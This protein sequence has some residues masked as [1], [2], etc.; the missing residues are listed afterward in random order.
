MRKLKKK[1]ENGGELKL[2]SF[3]FPFGI[4]LKIAT[5]PFITPKYGIKEEIDKYIIYFEIPGVRKE[6]IEV[7]ISKGY[8]RV[9]AK[10][11]KEIRDVLFKPNKYRRTIRIPEYVDIENVK[12]RYENGILIVTTPKKTPGR[13]IKVE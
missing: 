2:S 13:R 3:F 7:Y 9:I 5:S 10:V 12:S 4:A 1:R 8:L 6:D 11:P